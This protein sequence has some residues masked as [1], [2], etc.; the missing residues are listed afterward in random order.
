MTSAARD[1][2]SAI[3]TPACP[4]QAFTGSGWNTTLRV[5]M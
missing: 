1:T 4:S 3:L 5:A 2:V